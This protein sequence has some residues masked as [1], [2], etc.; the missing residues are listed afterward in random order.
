MRTSTRTIG[1]RHSPAP[2]RSNLVH[3]R[4]TE[5]FSSISNLID[6]P[7]DYVFDKI[8][9]LHQQGAAA[10]DKVFT[11]K[12]T[13]AHAIIQELFS[14]EHGG[15][16]ED[17]KK[18]ID[19]C[20][21]EVFNQKV[22]E[23]GGILLQS[24]NLSE[25]AIFKEQLHECVIAL[26]KLLEDN[27]LKVVG[28][29]VE[30]QDIKLEEFR[31]QKINISGSIDMLLQNEN[32][33]PV[34]FD[35]KYSPNADKYQDWIAENRSMHLALYKGLVQKTTGKN[36]KV[37]AYVLLPEVKV[38]TADELKG[39]IFKTA[40]DSERTGN[41]LKEMSNSYVFRK[42]QIL[43]GIVEDGEGLEFAYINKAIVKPSLDY[44]DKT[45]E[46]ALVP[47]DLAIHSRNKNCKK[48]ENPYSN[49]TIFKAGE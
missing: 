7:F 31:E 11:T 14:P 3:F 6:N 1:I 49:Y 44:V 13:V 19:S 36:A 27:K 42:N 43:N 17:I 46:E 18:Q 16:P 9:K 37:A 45:K 41:L 20:Y 15:I 40:V 32:Q 5:S 38:I 47:M 39:A 24:E 48:K 34:I 12:G 10:L 33:E 30:H 29:E 21:E 22:L 2:S 25:T 4:E 26:V 35:F 8:I 23:K 28:C